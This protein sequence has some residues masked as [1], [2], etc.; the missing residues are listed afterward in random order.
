MTIFV[1]IRHGLSVTNKGS[2]FTGQMDVPL[3]EEGLSEIFSAHLPI[4]V[5]KE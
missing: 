1:I 5:S 3:A 4:K 2:R